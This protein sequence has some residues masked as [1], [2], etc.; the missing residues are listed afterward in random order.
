MMPLYVVLNIA[1]SLYRSSVRGGQATVCLL[2]VVSPLPSSFCG[3]AA[4]LRSS[5]AP[6]LSSYNGRR[7]DRGADTALKGRGKANAL[8][9]EPLHGPIGYAKKAATPFLFVVC[10]VC[11]C[12]IE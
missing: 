3:A 12:T 10:C 7:C 9:H 1:R 6:P 4:E 8:H 11:F 5:L 2:C